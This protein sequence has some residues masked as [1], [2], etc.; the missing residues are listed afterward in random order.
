MTL[1]GRHRKSNPSPFRNIG[2]FSLK[3]LHEIG[4][5]TLKD[6]EAM[7]PVKA[8]V[9][10]KRHYPEDTTLLLLYSLQGT[11]MGIHW[12]AVPQ[13]IKDSLRARAEAALPGSNRKP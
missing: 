12:N 11:L 3:R 2:A 7:G 8:Y 1:Q 9:R 13:E 4:V 10:I 6:L 5:Y